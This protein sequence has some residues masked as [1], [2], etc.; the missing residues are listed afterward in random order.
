LKVK[1]FKKYICWVKKIH[2]LG[3]IIIKWA[4]GDKGFN[5]KCALCGHFDFYIFF[6]TCFFLKK[7]S[8][9]KLYYFY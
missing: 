7:N 2:D 8:H 1:E 6:A 4:N 3:E 9:N 5:H